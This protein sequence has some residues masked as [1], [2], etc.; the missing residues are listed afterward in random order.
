MGSEPTSSINFSIVGCGRIAQRHAK[1]I[2]SVGNLTAV[3]DV[4]EERASELAEAHDATPYT[5]LDDM[6]RHAEDA[7]VVAI[8]TP[9]GLHAEHTIRA[10]RTGYHVLCEKPMALSVSD[11]GRMI[12][13]AE[14]ANKRLFVVKQNRFNPPVAAMKAAVEQGHLGRI[15]S[16][17]LNCFWNRHQQ[18]YR[19]SD[20]RGSA[21]LDGGV[22]FTQFSHFIDLMY[23]VVGDVVEAQAVTDNFKHEE[24][25]EFADTGV[26]T[27]QFRNG[28]LGGIHFTTNAHGGNMEGS[29]TLFGENGTIKV[30]GEYLNELEYQDIADHTIEG[31]KESTGA[32]DYGT[33][34]GSMSNHDKVYENL[35]RVFRGDEEASAVGYEG[36]KTVEIIEKIHDAVEAGPA[37]EQSALRAVR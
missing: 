35:V 25:T 11:C 6:L 36:L 10:V 9:N 23:W 31:L 19:N 16:I 4:A 20:W 22:L 24:T 2:S 13:E 26:V 37:A 12:T 30:G 21:E 8:C 28:A 29:I 33:Y 3:C 17:Q 27:L 1:H 5:D 7:D 32:N 18:Y 14:K 34:T 15:Y